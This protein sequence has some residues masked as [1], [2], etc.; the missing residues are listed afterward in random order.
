MKHESIYIVHRL[1]LLICYFYGK[2]SSDFH[3][4]IRTTGFRL[5]SVQIGL[6]EAQGR[7]RDSS[8]YL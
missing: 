8:S 2:L 6:S 1:L 4:K 5:E 3:Q 7:L